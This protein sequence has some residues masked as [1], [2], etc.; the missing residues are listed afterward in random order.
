MIARDAGIVQHRVLVHLQ[1]RLQPMGCRGVVSGARMP[2]GTGPSETTA[3]TT[4]AA[5]YQQSQE[6][7]LEA[8]TEFA[9][10]WPF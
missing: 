4:Y 6:G 1:P 7:Q 2:V 9:T 3:I 8:A 5:R 10:E